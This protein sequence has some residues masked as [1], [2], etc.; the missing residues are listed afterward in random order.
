MR[1]H[2]LVL[3]LW[4]RPLSA[5]IGLDMLGE[6]RADCHDL[7]LHSPRHTVVLEGSPTYWS[8][9]QLDGHYCPKSLIVSSRTGLSRDRVQRRL[10]YHLATK[11][12]LYREGRMPVGV[13][14]M[15][16]GGRERMR[17]SRS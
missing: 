12:M 10:E 4:D 14:D 7:E 13:S 16:R 8:K 6:D 11:E 1:P 17:S 2:V 3:V 5:D 9:P 15:K